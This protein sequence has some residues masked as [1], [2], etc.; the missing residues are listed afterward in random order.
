MPPRPHNITLR[1]SQGLTLME[2]EARQP[3]RTVR[4]PPGWERR[5]AESEAAF[6]VATGGVKTPTIQDP[7]LRA[8]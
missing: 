6:K 8:G 1:T 5:G 3:H 7:A 2:G 4:G